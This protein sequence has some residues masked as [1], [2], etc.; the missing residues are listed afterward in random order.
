MASSDRLLELLVQWE[1]ERRQGRAPTA[2][3]L[4]PDDPALQATLRDRIHQREC[5]GKLWTSLGWS[6]RT[7]AGPGSPAHAGKSHGPATGELPER[8]RLADHGPCGPELGPVEKLPERLAAEQHD[9]LRG[10]GRGEDGS[11]ERA[12]GSICRP[13]E[14]RGTPRFAVERR[15]GAGGMGVVYRAY[16]RERDQVVAIKTLRFVDAAAIYRLK[17][18]FRALADIVHP[19]LVPVFRVTRMRQKNS[20]LQENSWVSLGSGR[21]PKL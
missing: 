2:E 16:D 12:V 15:I 17:R 9:T 5:Y 21:A 14:F 1:E 13:E 4:C 10:W 18:E 11:G 19:N 20:P 7:E 3:E 6:E 8:P